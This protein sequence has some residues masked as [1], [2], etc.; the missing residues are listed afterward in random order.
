M[1]L[2]NKKQVAIILLAVGLGLVSAILTA[3]HI[4]TSI[5]KETARLSQE[6]ENKKIKPLV[7][8]IKA[9]Q[10]E[11][12]QLATRQANLAARGKRRQHCWG[13]QRRAVHAEVFFGPANPRREKGVH[14]QH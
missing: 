13:R 8:E 3:N 2:E 4:Q 6:Y 5:K 1:N 12:K 10:K 14:C 7:R 9:L 11:M